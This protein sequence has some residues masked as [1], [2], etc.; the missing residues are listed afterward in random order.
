M[1]DILAGLGLFF[2]ALGVNA[3]IANRYGIVRTDRLV[4]CIPPLL[5]YLLVWYLARRSA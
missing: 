2:A 3:T 5:F 1:K 4:M